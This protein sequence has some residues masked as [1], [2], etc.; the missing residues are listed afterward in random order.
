MHIT[1]TYKNIISIKMSKSSKAAN[2]DEKV[3]MTIWI[4][5]TINGDNHKK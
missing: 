5:S 1:K 2:E 4:I 3:M